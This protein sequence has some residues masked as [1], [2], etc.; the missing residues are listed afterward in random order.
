[1]NGLWWMESIIWGI[2]VEKFG[3]FERD[4]VLKNWMQSL[5]LSFKREDT[6]WIY[7]M[8]IQPFFESEYK[9]RL[10]Y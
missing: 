4:C 9:E 6:S 10:K 1:V 5:I 3:D 2:I 7:F 8:N